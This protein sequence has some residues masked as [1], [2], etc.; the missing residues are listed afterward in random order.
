VDRYVRVYSYVESD[1]LREWTN[2][3]VIVAMDPD[4][5]VNTDVYNL[6][7]FNYEQVYVGYLNVYHTLPGNENIDVQ[8]ITS[9]NGIDFTRVCRRQVFL[10]SGDL[11]Y[12][13]YMVMT[14]YQSEPIIVDDT[15]YIYYEGVNYA[16][17]V[18]VNPPHGG[19]AVGLATFKRDRFVSLE[20]A[21]NLFPCR[22]VTRPFVVHHPNL[23]L[24]A[25][26]WADGS[27]RVELLTREWKTIPGF[28]AAECEAI[29]GNAL[30]H[31][32]RWTDNSNLAR[33]LGKEVRVKFH[34]ADARIHAISL[35]DAKRKLGEITSLEIDE[36]PLSNVRSGAERGDV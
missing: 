1:D 28:T 33:V 4:D 2:Y 22:L 9:R 8:L 3:R 5:P 36:Q 17:N 7:C 26:T 18:E 30:A 11:G 10:P 31:P 21:D 25:A 23:S 19:S 20:T 6:A 14:G 12:F 34:M 13:D 24:N 27:I 32:V 16:H 15:V 35:D 29:R